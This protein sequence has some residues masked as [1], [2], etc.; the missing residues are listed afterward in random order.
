MSDPMNLVP[1]VQ[2]I[3][4]AALTSGVALLATWLLTARRLSRPALVCAGAVG[5]LG[6]GV[7]AGS[8]YLPGSRL[9]WPPSDDQGRLLL[10]LFPA[11]ILVELLGAIPRT[12]WPAWLLRLA[13]AANAAPVLL[14][15]SVYLTQEPGPESWGW[16]TA[17]K[18][19]FLS[20]Q[21]AALAGVW[22]AL[23]VLAARKPGRSV[24]LALACCC[25]AAAVAAMLS[26]YATAGPLGLLLAAALTSTATV[27]LVLRAPADF[28]GAVGL[29]V[30]G[31][32]S[33][34]VVGRFFGELSIAS[35][36]LLFLAPLLCWVPELP[37]PERPWPRL[38]GALRVV[39][40]A[41]PLAAALWLTQHRPVEVVT[42]T[43]I[44]EGSIDDYRNF[45]K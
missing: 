42:E 34:V 9:H 22:A 21:A 44:Q 43:D 45:G 17:Q 16:T 28:R 19:L 33:L 4:L 36:A 6:L 35:A 11:S 25:A 20:A 29:G 32:F 12:R 26:G 13:I 31:L 1:L 27:S 14:Y 24:P 2:S 3:A 23:H 5:A 41:A 37:Y 8:G 39:L 30:V 15:G 18:W 40:T 38:R 7:Y 10:T